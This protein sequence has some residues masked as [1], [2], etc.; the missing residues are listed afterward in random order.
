[1]TMSG[2]L[3]IGV[4]PGSF[5]PMHIGHYDVIKKASRIFDKVVIARGKNPQKDSPTYEIPALIK[6]D[7]TYAEYNGLLTEFITDYFEAD[8]NVTIIRGLRNTTDLQY[9]ITQYQYL[10]DFLPNIQLISIFCEPE[11][12]HISS[13]GLKQLALYTDISKYLVK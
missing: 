12:Q 6:R 3:K 5:S 9:E 10:R 4:Y 8:D 2:N 11:F 7:Y 1:M 13:S